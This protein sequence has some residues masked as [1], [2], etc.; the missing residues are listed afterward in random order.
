MSE[1]VLA[2]LDGCR[3]AVIELQ[4]GL[5]AIPAL[6]PDNGG[7]G[8][9][10]KYAYV[11]DYLQGLGFADI[12]DIP[13]PDARVPGGQRPNLAAVLPGMDASRTLWVIAH[14]DIVPPGDLALWTSDP[15]RLVV[16]GDLIFGR[17]VEDNHQALVSAAM[18][19]GGLKATGGVPPINFGLVCVADEE[20]GSKY[21]LDYI[22]KAAPELFK[23]TDLILVPD[24]GLPDGS[25]I[26]VAEKSMFWL[27]VTVLGKQCHASVP[28]QGVNT[29][30]AAADFILR[31]RGLKDD[32]PATD[33][34]FDPPVSTFEPTKKE[35]N[36]ENVN[37]VPG[38][39]VF[40]VDCRVLPVYQVDAVY[41]RLKAIGETVAG[42]HGVRIEYEVVQMEQATAPTDPESEIVTRLRRAI[43]EVY[44]VSARPMGIGGGTVAAYLRRRGLPAAVWAKIM[45]NAHQ[46]N[47]HASISNCIGD[48]KVM[49][50]LLFG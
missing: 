23:P 26:E 30:V 11:R 15:Y 28:G 32:F 43:R 29:L 12:R 10:A 34:M 6:G 14:L 35:A 9:A 44:D 17:G 47:E 2:Y 45:H 5:V 24:S 16:D 8:E 33:A 27:K 19:A 21:G 25:M 31:V 36:V 4:R 46:P 22:L 40:Y 48:A 38:R 1:A 7:E 3:E 42:R 50:R 39:D 20:T 37:T 18:V 41:A 49:A 13:A